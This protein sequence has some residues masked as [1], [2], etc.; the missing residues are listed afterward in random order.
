VE[1][2]ERAKGSGSPLPWKVDTKDEG[3]TW[4]VMEKEDVPNTEPLICGWIDNSGYA[5][6]SRHLDLIVAAVNLVAPLA[7]DWQR[8]KHIEE[9]VRNPALVLLE[10]HPDASEFVNGQMKEAADE[11]RAALDLKEAPPE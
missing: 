5:P 2:V 9:A 6:I 11:L 1:L 10:Y 4:I 7:R 3:E 8:L